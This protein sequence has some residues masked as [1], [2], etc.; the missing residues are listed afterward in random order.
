MAC[1]RTLIGALG[2][3]QAY[4]SPRSTERQTRS[5]RE[6]VVL[7]CAVVLSTDSAARTN[8]SNYTREISEIFVDNR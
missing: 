2:I 6:T 1:A 5:L 7:I 8:L 4:G 3:V